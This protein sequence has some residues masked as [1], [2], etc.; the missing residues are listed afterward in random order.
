MQLCGLLLPVHFFQPSLEYRLFLLTAGLRIPFQ[1]CKFDPPR[2]STTASHKHSKVRWK[3]LLNAAKRVRHA[4]GQ[5]RIFGSVPVEQRLK[6][7]L[8]VIV[9]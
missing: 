7:A 5:L 2:V 8:P 4:E 1:A 6:G 3:A 9:Q